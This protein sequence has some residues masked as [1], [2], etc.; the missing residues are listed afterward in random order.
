MQ[1]F[2]PSCRNLAEQNG[3]WLSSR[4]WMVAGQQGCGWWLSRWWLASRDEDGGPAGMWM[5]AGQPDVVAGQ[6]W[7]GKKDALSLS[8][9]FFYIKIAELRLEVFLKKL[10]IIVEL[11]DKLLDLS[12]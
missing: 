10:W 6:P 8:D 12:I 1:F 11:G 9:S 2:V 3:W 5:V 4:M 7:M